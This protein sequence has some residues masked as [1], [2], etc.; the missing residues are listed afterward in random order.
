MSH[1]IK[2]FNNNL[3]F[4]PRK[5]FLI[6]FKS[7]SYGPSPSEFSLSC[8]LPSYYWAP[9]TH[10]S[11]FTS[12]VM[13]NSSASRQGLLVRTKSEV[14]SLRNYIVFNYHELCL[15]YSHN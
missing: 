2:V 5:S 7:H 15:Q 6:M 8:V 10:I 3:W 1:W 11:C 13:M 4:L 12:N 14:L 9:F